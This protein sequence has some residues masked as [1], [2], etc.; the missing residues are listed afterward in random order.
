MGVK[1][2][3]EQ[4]GHLQFL[5]TEVLTPGMLLSKVDTT[6]IAPH[7]CKPPFCMSRFSLEPD[8]SSPLDCHNEQE[9][10]FV[11]SGEGRL[12]CNATQIIKITAGDVIELAPGVSHTVHNNGQKQL[13]VFSVW[14]D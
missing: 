12:T 13:V 6:P 10:W 5:P 3:T 1:K 14:W 11:A 2:E 8:I 7:A 4:A 9:L